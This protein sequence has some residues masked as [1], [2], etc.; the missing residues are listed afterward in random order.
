MATKVGYYEATFSIP[1]RIFDNFVSFKVEDIKDLAHARQ[2]ERAL[3][4]GGCQSV[5]VS[6]RTPEDYVSAGPNTLP[7][8]SLRAEGLSMIAAWRRR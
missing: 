3:L 2:I 1:S 7:E 8:G 6:Q 4:D 5:Y